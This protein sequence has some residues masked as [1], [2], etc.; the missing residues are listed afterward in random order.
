MGS[1]LVRRLLSGASGLDGT[2]FDFG[3]RPTAT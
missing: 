1:V 2:T 3:W